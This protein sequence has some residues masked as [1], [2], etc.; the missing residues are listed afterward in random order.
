LVEH[1][2]QAGRRY[3]CTPKTPE[4]SSFSADRID[5]VRRQ[6]R[7]ERFFDPVIDP[8]LFKFFTTPRTPRLLLVVMLTTR[9]FLKENRLHFNRGWGNHRHRFG[10]KFNDWLRHWR[11]DG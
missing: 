6:R 4:D 3:G 11:S 10:W 2:I 9:A 8:P 5:R 1:F 7:S